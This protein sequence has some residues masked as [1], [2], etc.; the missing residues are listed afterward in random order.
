MNK[1]IQL[2]DRGDKGID[3]SFASS[4]SSKKSKSISKTNPKLFKDAAAYTKHCKIRE[5]LSIES[6][7]TDVKID[8][9]YMYTLRKKHYSRGHSLTIPGMDPEIHP[10]GAAPVIIKLRAS[11]PL[12]PSRTSLLSPTTNLFNDEYG[13]RLESPSKVAIRQSGPGWISRPTSEL[14]QNSGRI[15]NP[16]VI[17]R[18]PLRFITYACTED[19][20][21]PTMKARSIGSINNLPSPI[22]K[23]DIGVTTL[24]DFYLD[25]YAK[26]PK[27]PRADKHEIIFNTEPGPPLSIDYEPSPNRRKKRHICRQNWT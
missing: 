8:D 2:I 1:I 24:K 11:S 3:N 26:L 7:P 23:E 22:K 19:K 13:N 4:S 10:K 16:V 14:T 6:K 18:P 21:A 20:I 27:L 12:T 25:P 15:A 5:L 9:N 17:F